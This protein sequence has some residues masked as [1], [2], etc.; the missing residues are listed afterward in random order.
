[1]P[2]I[3]NRKNFQEIYNMQKA[4]YDIPEIKDMRNLLDTSVLRFRN[5]NAFAE[6]MPDGK[7]AYTTY[8]QLNHNVDAL[9]T[10]FISMGLRGKKIAVCGEN[11]ARWCQV[12]LSAC[13]AAS[14]IVPIDKELPAPEIINIINESE[15]KLVVADKKV[16]QKLDGEKLLKRC[17]DTVCLDGEYNACTS[18]ENLLDKGEK[19]L[20]TGKTQFLNIEI[21]PNAL[22][23]L[24]FTSGTTGIAKGVMLSQKNICSDIVSA[25]SVIRISSADTELSV[26]P[27]HH[28]YEC[29]VVL[30]I[31]NAG[32][33]VAFCGGLRHLAEGFKDFRPSVLC[34]VPLI[35]EK[36][37]SKIVSEPSARAALSLG[38]AAEKFNKAIFSKVHAFFGGRLR[39]IIV[40]AAAINPKVAKDFCHMGIPVIIGY[41]MTECSPII[42]C[43]NDRD[44]RSDSI[45]KPLPNAE[46]KIIDPDENGVGEICVRGP[47]V[48][49]GYYNAPAQ[50]AAAI[51]DGWLHTGDLGTVDKDGFFKITGR[52]KNIILTKNGKNI[53]P[54]VLEYYLC[55][56]EVISEAVVYSQE[57]DGN[58][59]IVAEIYP[60][61]EQITKKLKKSDVS[62]AEISTVVTS[63]VKSINRKRPSHE[64]I[65]KIVLR[66]T[67]FSKTTTKKI[68]RQEI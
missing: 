21:D 12:Y 10:A 56:S 35:V 2:R 26:L 46:A 67:E 8:G 43:N 31:L 65:Q 18:Y 48:T 22:S 37:H 68:K 38:K 34:A 25:S 59:L 7:I 40:G 36:L 33:C 1:M 3:N 13:C 42:I 16:L 23:V 15:T 4:L 60:D 62:K 64:S 49:C 50:T 53:Y 63:A 24:L 39:L 14:V 19:L 30:C 28:A 27:L 17:P 29:L 11:S 47:M 20:S 6:K 32:G 66:E 52:V 55:K 9:V 58:E 61:K 57:T 41:G 51:K 44:Y 5:N 54:E 45:G